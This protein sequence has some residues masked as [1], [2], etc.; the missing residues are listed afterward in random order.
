MREIDLRSDTVTLPT[1]SMREAMGRAEVGD[2]VYG[3]DPTVRRLEE[4]AAGRL[5]KEAA[6]FVPSGTMGNLIC[7][8]THCS[9]GEE[10]ILGNRSHIFVN[11][12]GGLSAVGGLVAHTIP[13]RPDGTLALKDIEQ[14]I[15]A[16]NIHFP[17]TGL[18]CLENTHNRCSGAPLTAAYT[19]A[20]GRLARS[21]GLRV[22]LD[23]ARLFNAA[24]ALGVDAKDLVRNVD[25][26]LFC[27]SKG[28]C[29]PV[30]SVVCGTASFI[31]EARRK[32][33][34][35]GGGMRQAGV[36]AAAGMIALAE[37]VD[38]LAEDHRNARKLAEGLAGIPG[39]A[40]DPAVAKTNILYVDL[41]D[42]GVS[43]EALM[44]GL[45]GRGVKVLRTG[46]ARFRLVTHRGISGDD[47]DDA[48]RAFRDVMGASNR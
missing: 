24:V 36:L 41:A 10:V 20:V 26:V 5:G 13:N 40:A 3:E 27:F 4:T 32:R 43:A 23:G 34:M 22:H 19:D 48:L 28:L 37:M 47:V 15:R 17:R 45:S 46:P 2:D 7:L 29:A 31:S 14:A 18:V 39:L 12:A 8:L 25:S 33:K 11:E 35:L 30:G 38:R 6:L 44:K 42:G 1:P 21:R 16:D 9:R